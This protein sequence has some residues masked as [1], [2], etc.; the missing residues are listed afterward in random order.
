MDPLNSPE[1][2]TEDQK[3]LIRQALVAR[4]LFAHKA[5]SEAESGSGGVTNCQVCVCG[6]HTYGSTWCHLLQWMD[7]DHPQASFSRGAKE[8]DKLLKDSG[9]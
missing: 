6:F 7:S 2:W 3:S 9:F 8:L 4:C 1:P 5:E